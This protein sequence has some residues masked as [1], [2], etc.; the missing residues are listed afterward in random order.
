[1]RTPINNQAGFSL[2]EILVALTL[3]ALAGTFVATKVFDTLQEGYVKNTKIQISGFRTSLEEFRRHCNQFPTTQQGLEA[4]ISKPSVAPDCQ[5]YPP[6]GILNANK[7][8]LDAW[9]RPYQY[10]SDGT[11][12]VITSLGRDGKEGGENLFDKDIRS[13]E[14]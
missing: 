9:G 3:L 2:V 14:L 5:N 1:M 13:D 10:E 4:L 6:S 7:V 8:P 11:K 12:Y